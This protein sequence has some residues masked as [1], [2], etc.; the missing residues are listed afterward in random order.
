MILLANAA[1]F[2]DAVGPINDEWIAGAAKVRSELFTPLK[3][4]VAGPSPPSW[5]L[6][7]RSVGA[8]FVEALEHIGGRFT[9]TVAGGLDAK[10]T[11]HVALKARAVVTCDVDDNCIVELCGS[12]NRIDDPAYL[13]VG[14]GH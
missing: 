5:I 2:F 10:F 12:G 7:A 3:R 13:V 8:D 11:L 9:H 4:R 6:R 1:G 14:L